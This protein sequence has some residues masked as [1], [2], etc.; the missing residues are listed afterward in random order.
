MKQKFSLN[1]WLRK[2]PQP[3]AVLADDKRVEVP[4]HGRSWSDLTKTLQAL[5]PSKLIALNGQG[6]VI[7]STVLDDD[8]DDSEKVVVTPEMSD[9]QLYAK[10][11]AEAYE[12]GATTYAPLLKAAME[13]VERQGVR[14]AKTETELEAARRELAALRAEN[15]A[16]RAVPGGGDEGISGILGPIVA[17]AIAGGALPVLNG[18]ARAAA[19]APKQHQQQGAKK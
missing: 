2:T 12:K 14:L 19:G 4:K 9:T 1:H 10:L 8:D 11:I 5:E 18:G 16:L 17:S 15:A 7:R 13:F 6:E 3:V